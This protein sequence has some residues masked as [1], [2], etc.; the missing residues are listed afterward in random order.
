MPA[1]WRMMYEKITEMGR[2]GFAKMGEIFGLPF[3]LCEFCN[4][5]EVLYNRV[6]GDSLP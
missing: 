5:I 2:L 1:I 6:Y 4:N 3:L